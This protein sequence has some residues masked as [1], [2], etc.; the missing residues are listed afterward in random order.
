MNSN[1]NGYLA[2]KQYLLPPKHAPDIVRVTGDIVALH[3][4]AATGPYLALWARVP[5]FARPG[6]EEA[7]Y[8]RRELVRTLCMRGTLHVVPSAELAFLH[9][10]YARRRSLAE[11]KRI[12]EMLVQAGLCPP[13]HTAGMLDDLHDQ[14]LITLAKRGP[15]TV[16]EI[17]QEVPALKAKVTY[18]VGKPYEGT[19][20]LGSRLI[21]G[22]CSSGIL[23]RGRPRGT[24]R[25]NLYEYAA[26]SDW[27]P[28]VDL[29]TIPPQEAQTWLVKRYLS[30]FG[31]ATPDDVQ[32]WTGFSKRE[33]QQALQSID[34]ALVE[35]TVDGLGNGYLMLA[36][37]AR[38]FQDFS[39]PESPYV[40][41]LPGL[42]PYIMGYRDRGRFLKE[43]HHSKV[44]DR[45][46]NA[47]PTVWVNG[48]V[49]GAWGQR[50]DGSV[51]FGL[52]D[53]VDAAA[54]ELLESR[55]EELEAFLGGEYLPSP[56]QT[57]F[58]R[59]LGQ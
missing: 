27:L 21:P 19:F 12:T 51:V 24:W 17:S 5:G 47:M 10:A 7:L 58:T 48:Q 18:A 32:W 3:A 43:K 46:G 6:L 54:Q 40:F 8:E 28:G 22:M 1:V 49:A 35:T 30:A 31:P 41:F 4:T 33:T 44:F 9:Q 50:K 36:G 57:P 42:D 53:P 29:E 52:F 13:E 59:G 25:S 2:I 56:T 20:S 34:E 38:Q 14:V 37:D 23:V 45:A 16:D 11:S 26:L 39:P 15:S 55:R